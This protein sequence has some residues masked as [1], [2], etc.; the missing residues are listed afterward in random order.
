MTLEELDN[1]DWAG[2]NH[3]Y[4]SAA[5]V[6]EQLRALRATDPDL[7]QQALYD[8]Y[9]NIFHQGSRYEASAHAVPF[10]LN[11]AADADTPQRSEIVLLLAG[12]AI[13]Y[14]EALLP[15][16]VN[17]SVWREQVAELNSADPATIHQQYDEWVAR[18]A[19]A[20]E[21]RVR[22]LH[23]TVAEYSLEHRQADHELAAYDAVR[24]GVP[25]LC[26][27]LDD[28]AAEVR[29]AAAYTLAWFPEEASHVV[30][31]LMELLNAESV[32][33]VAATAIVSTGLVGDST[34]ADR[35]RAY[36]SDDDPLLR[37][38]AATALARLEVSDPE[39]VGC[40]AACAVDPP[41]GGIAFLEGDVRGYSSLSLAL[42][43]GQ[44]PPDAVSAV[45]AGLSRSSGTRAFTITSA[46]LHLTF[47][48]E[49][50]RPRP[51]YE[52]LTEQQRRTV[53]T[54]AE[55]DGKTWQWGNFTE[56]LRAWNLPAAREE[57]R[58][59]AG[60]PGTGRRWRLF[61]SSE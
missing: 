54:L 22:E 6:P 38:A 17:I 3:A 12:L 44:A 33:S 46:A 23:R 35:F 53:R 45:L 55:L 21:R 32:S 31:R 58:Q 18:A 50:L 52:K 59:Y 10:L 41:D 37:W 60:L 14:D 36:L 5:D 40:L 16:G 1:V 30:P 25:T 48:A 57:M 13:G 61:G 42:L 56:I 28:P 34:L 9:G 7:R 27:L 4:G 26:L 39:V 49:P 51:P 29:A 11:L 24:A 19:D 43:E 15:Q 20:Q 2:L 47:G 8:L